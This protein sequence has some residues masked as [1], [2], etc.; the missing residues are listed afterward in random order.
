M[1][2]KNSEHNL[3][4]N[5]TLDFQSE[6]NYS[7]VYQSKGLSIK[8]KLAWSQLFDYES[9]K[10][11]FSVKCSD[12]GSRLSSIQKVIDHEEQF[13]KEELVEYIKKFVL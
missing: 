1:L 9:E 12:L 7:N 3:T 6:M 11:K 10:N 8:E 13:T 2:T 5:D 4:R